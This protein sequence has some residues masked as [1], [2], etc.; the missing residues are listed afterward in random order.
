MVKLENGSKILLHQAVCIILVV[1]KIAEADQALCIALLKLL[2]FYSYLVKL[3][4]IF[5]QLASALHISNYSCPRY[6]DNR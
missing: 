3:I 6:A 1:S 4:V 5:L 2:Y